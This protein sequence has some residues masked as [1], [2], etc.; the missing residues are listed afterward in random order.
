[1]PVK[2]EKSLKLT[3]L[4][5]LLFCVELCILFKYDCEDLTLKRTCK[6]AAFFRVYYIDFF[7]Y[8]F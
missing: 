6:L 4:Q 8:R 1:M 3:R 7:F 5:D 2:K